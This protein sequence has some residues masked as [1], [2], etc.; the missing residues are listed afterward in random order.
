MPREGTLVHAPYERLT[1]EQVSRIHQASV[2]ILKDP[3]LLC[4]NSEAADIF[5]NS[6]A[7]VTPVTSSDNPCWLIKIPE[8]LV[9][10]AL[11]SAPKTVKLF[12]FNESPYQ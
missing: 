12:A 2:E 11:E 6:G 8:K 5:S 9:S 4:F 1:G 3:G 7:E 10:S